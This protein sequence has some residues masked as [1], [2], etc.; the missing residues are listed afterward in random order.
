MK[1]SAGHTW[2]LVLDLPPGWY[3]FKCVVL[4]EKTGETI[5]E[6]GSDRSVE[7]KAGQ[8]TMEVSCLFNSTTTTDVAPLNAARAEEV[9]AASAAARAALAL[10]QPYA[11]PSMEVGGYEG[12]TT[13]FP[14]AGNMDALLASRSPWDTA[15][16]GHSNGNGNNGVSPLQL[17]NAL[18][19]G[20]DDARGADNPR[21]IW[22]QYKSSRGLG[23]LGSS[24]STW[25]SMDDYDSDGGGGMSRKGGR[26]LSRSGSAASW[27]VRWLLHPAAFTL[28]SWVAPRLATPKCVHQKAT[29]E[30][31]TSTQHRNLHIT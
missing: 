19:D 13:S 26:S 10:E 4:N 30:H 1:W 7:I 14:S 5:W 12:L 23:S 21:S 24:S 28:C 16:N 15:S 27:L 8:R 9:L 11:Q 29:P 25:G 17:S 31:C 22:E 18:T 6:T 3:Q 2:M 20:E